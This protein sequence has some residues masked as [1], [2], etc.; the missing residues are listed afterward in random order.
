M[1]G[2]LRQVKTIE[3]A[4]QR[5]THSNLA[6]VSDPRFQESFTCFPPD[7]DV[8]KESLRSQR[9]RTSH[10]HHTAN[11]HRAWTTK[12][13]KRGGLKRPLLPAFI[14]SSRCRPPPRS[15]VHS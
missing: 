8:T 10:R 2:E 12:S 1:P 5:I 13:G 11:T 3:D 14:R 9:Q 4:N 6:R 7:K 15:L